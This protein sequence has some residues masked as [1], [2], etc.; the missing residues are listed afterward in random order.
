MMSPTLEL[1]LGMNTAPDF[2]YCY[3]SDFKRYYFVRDWYFEDAFWIASLECD[4]L[5][6]YKDEIGNTDLYALRSA[7]NYDGRIIDNVYP[8]KS[9]CSFTSVSGANPWTATGGMFVCGI[10]NNSG[11]NNTEYQ[12]GSL[13]YNIFTSAQ[14]GILMNYLMTDELFNID[15]GFNLD[16]ASW[17]IQKSI[18]DPL[19]YIK[20]CVYIP[21]ASSVITS[22]LTDLVTPMV[23]D[24]N[25]YAQTSQ[26]GHPIGLA[27]V[28]KRN[29]PSIIFNRTFN[30]PKHP[31]TNSRGAYVNQSPYTILTLL[32]PPFGV[33]DVDTT[34]TSN[35][36]TINA[37]IEI[38]I[39]TGLGI[40]TVSCNGIVLNRIEA[41]VGIPI[42]LSQI[43]R[44]YIGGVSSII[45]GISG[46][47]TGALSGNVAG[48]ISSATSGI[49]NA[50]SSLAP[51][52]QTIGTGGSYAQITESPR[53]DAQFFEIVDDDINK[54]GRPCCKIIKPKN[55]SGYLLI[56]DGDVAING[57][58]EESAKIKSYLEGG[59]YWE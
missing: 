29:K 13:Q 38:D 59:F 46:T 58:A 48:A 44:D 8:T 56:Q 17:Q 42:Q 32:I 57:T 16:D 27:T 53:L 26:A 35:A 45:N 20:S 31:Q 10:V 40:L 14:M 15:N 36:T 1:N 21:I 11:Y 47:I 33:I 25:V 41:Q 28:L 7:S 23:W 22:E 50:I 12:F 54:N 24:W 55:N 52:S 43:T 18:T 6:T 9:G 37:K 51:R 5:A 2:N 3:I 19:Q 34:I 4:V 39:P 49:G 30:I